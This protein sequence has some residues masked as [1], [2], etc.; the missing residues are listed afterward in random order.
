M[1]K[2]M[3]RS[4]ILATVVVSFAAAYAESKIVSRADTRADLAITIYN[5]GIALVRETRSMDLPNGEFHLDFLDIASEIDPTSVYFKS[6]TKPTAVRI[7]EQNYLFDLMTPGK[8]MEKYV[9]ETVM[10]KRPLGE[11]GT[12]E[13]IEGTLLSSNS[14][15]VYQ[16]GDK[17]HLNPFGEVILPELPGDLVSKPTLSW[18]LANTKEG[19]HKCEVSYITKGVRWN[20]D[21]VCVVAA[22]DDFIDLTGWVTIENTSGAAYPDATLKLIAGDIHRIE[23]PRRRRDRESKVLWSASAEGRGFEEKSFFEY[24]LYT[25]GR[26]ATIRN[27]EK[28]QMNLLSADH[29]PVEKAYVLERNTLAPRKQTR[30]EK[31]KVSVKFRFKN[32]GES[33]LGMPLPKGR[34][35]VYKADDADNSLQLLGEDEIDHTP[36]NENIEIKLGE[37]FDVVG[38]WKQTDYTSMGNDRYRAGYELSVRN[39]KTEAVDVEV[40]EKFPSEWIIPESTHDFEKVD[41][42]TTKAVVRVGADEEV[43]IRY[44]VEVRH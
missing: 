30:E 34:F 21:Y 24:H 11:T 14:G 38:T 39:R 16:F 17:I 6:L 10:L 41:A 36:R 37:A 4:L 1:N 32:D 23:P 25:L 8:L 3:F 2:T 28:K 31:K 44:S 40:I 35:R 29:I 19:N 20:A 42:A 9:G 33:N 26:K 15:H 12:Y 22:G 43:I 27:R 13:T 7:L 18:L 5:E